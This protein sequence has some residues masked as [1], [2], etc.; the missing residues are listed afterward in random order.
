MT[1]CGFA[2]HPTPFL[3]AKKDVFIV[4]CSHSAALGGGGVAVSFAFR[5]SMDVNL[6]ARL[7]SRSRMS[8]QSRGTRV[9]IHPRICTDVFKTRPQFQKKEKNDKQTQR[10]V[11]P[12]KKPSNAAS[13]QRQKLRTQVQRGTHGR[14]NRALTESPLCRRRWHFSPPRSRSSVFSKRPPKKIHFEKVTTWERKS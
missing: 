13:R 11:A 14:E 2:L 4:S 3:Y 12:G 9:F 1:S 6:R 8:I 10:T 7:S 5:V